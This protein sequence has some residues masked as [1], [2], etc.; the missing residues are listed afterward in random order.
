MLATI[1]LATI[2][3]GC[4]YSDYAP[5]CLVRAGVL[6]ARGPA[7]RGPAARGPAARGPVAGLADPGGRVP[8]AGYRK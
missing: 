8:V 5:A 6:A 1:T 4:D 7:A 3:Y 2:D